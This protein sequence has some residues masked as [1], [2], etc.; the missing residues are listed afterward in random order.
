MRGDPGF[1]LH[2][3][4][5]QDITEIWEYIAD[6]SPLA[7]RRVREEILYAIRALVPFPHSGYRRPNL[8][9]RPLRFKV[10]REYVIAYAPD[11]RPLWVIAVFHGR[12]DPLVIAA[13]LR[14]RE[15]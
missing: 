14:D 10:M 3:L 5:A 1:A 7:A 4:A 6:D 2:P 8:T 15:Q 9:S 11:K 12:R 13:M